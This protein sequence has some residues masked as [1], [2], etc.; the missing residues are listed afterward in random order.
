MG[1][2]LDTLLTELGLSLSI[3]DR[4]NCVSEYP[5]ISCRFFK[6]FPCETIVSE[7]WVDFLN[8]KKSMLKGILGHKSVFVVKI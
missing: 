4:V 8:H 3:R 5:I 7:L 1:S 6:H 2:D